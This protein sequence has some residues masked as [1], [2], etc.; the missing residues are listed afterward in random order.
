MKVGQNA[1]PRKTPSGI[2][3]DV[4]GQTFGKWTVLGF[5]KREPGATFWLCVCDCGSKHGIALTNLR[6]GK[7]TQC[8][9]CARLANSEHGRSRSQGYNIWRQSRDKLCK[10]WREDC[11]RFF[12]ECLSQRDGRSLIAI[13]RSKPIG[14]GNFAWA[15]LSG[16]AGLGLEID[17][18]W[19]TTAEAQ[20]ILGV[21]REAIRQRRSRQ[22]ATVVTRR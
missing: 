4:T 11:N 15:T 3:V 22:Q 20:E 2:R 14:P 5:W 18:T 7:S 17:G 13:D 16:G 9:D 1:K 8:S 10:E 21:S 12:L 6:S 19:K